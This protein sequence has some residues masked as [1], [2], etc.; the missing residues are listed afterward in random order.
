MLR[1]PRQ[2]GMNTEIED[3]IY[4]ESFLKKKGNIIYD[5]FQ[6]FDYLISISTILIVSK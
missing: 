5:H 4:Q 1:P 3:P 2:L 6:S